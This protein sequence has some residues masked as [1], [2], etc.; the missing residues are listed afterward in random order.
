MRVRIPSDDGP[1]ICHCEGGRHRRNCGGDDRTRSR[2]RCAGAAALAA[3]LVV[4]F[5]GVAAGAE[6]PPATRL[7]V[8]IVVDQLRGDLALRSR[9][10]WSSG[11]FRRLYDHG[12]VFSDAHHGHANTETIVGHATL[13]TGTDPSVHGMVGNVWLD[14]AKGD[15]HYNIEDSGSEIVGHD[16]RPASGKAGDKGDKAG[17]TTGANGHA[18]I[19]KPCSG[20]SPQTMLAPTIADS[21]VTAGGG[22]AKVFAVSLKDRAAVPMGGY[23]GKALWMSDATGE[24]LSSSY[25][26]PDRKLPAWVTSW[27]KAHHADH[28][29]GKTWKL[30]LPAKTYRFA[31][32]DDQPW[33]LPPAGMTRTFP[34]RLER[35]RLADGFYPALEASPFGDEL[36]VDFT[37][38]LIRSEHLGRDSVV[39]YLSVSFSSNDYI[40]HRYGPDSLEMEDEVLRIDRRIAELM[41]AADDAAGMG[42]TLFVLTADHGV[43][44]PPEE[45]A[46]QK[47][48]GGHIL[49]SAAENTAA[50]LR[51][52]KRV[53][54]GFIRR[55]P[56]YIYLDRD[57]LLSH[58]IEPEA[59]ERSVAAEIAKLPGVAFAFTRGDI[60]GGKLPDTL[61]ARSVARSFHPERSGDIHV[62]A[63]PGWQISF[64]LPTSNQFAT[65]HGTPWDYDTFVPLIFSGPGVPH[66]VVD[67]RV[68]ATDV[69]PTIAALLGVPAPAR[70][71]GHVL[72]EAIRKPPHR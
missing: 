56:P 72:A 19:R 30:L 45:L 2:V 25:Y 54:T 22:K 12:A 1:D 51:I 27:N 53:G 4:R 66:A 52:A 13:A 24:F 15:P 65:G 28:Y 42:H 10:R 29:D 11:G 68:D 46:A 16:S 61:V 38:E 70:A 55:W 71:T 8:E 17:A 64:E 67:R 58:G 49:L 18:D 59:A 37:R 35:S 32:K 43:A 6:K 33:E 62:V 47:I 21:V 39:D 26:Y 36:L 7:V 63:K 57:A 14:R 23:T 40:G 31:G 5:G 20:R 9:D 34:H 3:L 69:A 60:Q 41:K 44:E 48:D 50:A